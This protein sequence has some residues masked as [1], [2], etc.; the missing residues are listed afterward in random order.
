MSHSADTADILSRSERATLTLSLRGRIA[1]ASSDGAPSH[2]STSSPRMSALSPKSH[3]PLRGHRRYPLAERE[4]YINPLAPREDSSSLIG[5]CSFSFLY[6]LSAN[7]RSFA[8]ES[9]PTPRTPQI[10]SRGARGLH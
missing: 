4:G 3:V 9:C 5:R 1:A 7:E 10:S 8:E 6:K 2:F